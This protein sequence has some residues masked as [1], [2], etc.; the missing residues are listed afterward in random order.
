MG[1]RLRTAAV[2]AVTAA[3]AYALKRYYSAAGAEELR[4]I[5][6]P[7]AALV[8]AVTGER[9]LWEAGYGY[10]SKAYAF[11]IAPSCAGVNFLIV[12]ACSAILAFCGSRRSWAGAVLLIGGGFAAAYG[13][14]VLANASRILVSLAVPGSAHAHRVTGIAVF[15]AFLFAQQVFLERRLARD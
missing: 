12:S 10:F 8:S 11:V 1:P 7:T 3:C 2:V 15:L 14:T 13:W 4:W 6:G 5:L 9:F